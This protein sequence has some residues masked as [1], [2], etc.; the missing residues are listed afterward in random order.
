MSGRIVSIPPEYVSERV[1]L[2]AREIQIGTN[3]GFLESAEA[4]QLK[5][6]SIEDE[7]RD[8]Q[9]VWAYLALSWILD[10]PD[11]YPD[12]WEAIEEVWERLGHFDEISGLIRWMPA[13]SGE[14]LGMEGMERRWRDYV[15]AGRL[16][17]LTK[18]SSPRPG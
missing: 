2:S 3:L 6:A 8:P 15:Q 4:G 16:R 1:D 17:Y 10:N 11:A 9:G 12:P 13:R 7:Q 18:P 14:P 5:P